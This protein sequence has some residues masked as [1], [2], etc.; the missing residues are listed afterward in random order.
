VNGFAG[1]DESQDLFVN[2]K[3]GERSLRTGRH[4]VREGRRSRTTTRNQMRETR[5]GIHSHM[6]RFP[7]RRT[8]YKIT[9]SSVC[10]QCDTPRGDHGDRR[11]SGADARPHHRR[12]RRSRT[13][14]GGRVG[15]VHT[16]S[17]DGAER[18][19]NDG[20]SRT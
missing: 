14:A 15:T 8:S 5:G 10:H 19:V 9:R 18:T 11:A 12:E 13:T 6:S 16:G 20:T 1:A 3:H 2:R 7:A 17:G 4:G